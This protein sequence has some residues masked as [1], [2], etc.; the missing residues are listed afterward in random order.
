AARSSRPTGGRSSPRSRRIS[1]TSPTTSSRPGSSSG[2]DENLYRALEE[3]AFYFL[4]KPF[5]RRVLLALV[6]RCLRLK[7][8]RRAKE[9]FSRQAQADLEQARRFQHSLLPRGTVS[10]LGWK[11]EGRFR[12]CDA[13]GGDFYQVHQDLRGSLVFSL[14]DV[15]GHGVSAAMVAGMVRSALD[16]ARR[17][18]PDPVHVISEV[19]TGADFLSAPRFVTLI[20]GQLFADGRCR[21]GNA[22]HPPLLWLGAQPAPRELSA[23]G[24]LLTSS[25]AS[26]NRRVEEVHLAVG[27]RLLLYSDGLFEARDAADRELGIPGVAELFG[28]TRDLPLGEALDRL[29]T[30]LARHCG[31]RPLE[32]D[33]T[34][35]LLER[36]SQAE[37]TGC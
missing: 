8:E 2:S 19:A 32:D 12:P 23:T 15:V 34:L 22:G 13:L 33:V 11:A 7:R 17:K 16:A 36:T 6:E 30:E 28:E 21:Y 31:G 27:D 18:N 37:E 10:A 9:A 35:L 4:Y 14:S 5:E 26:L 29:L 1:T 24:P 20:Y 3:N 25:L